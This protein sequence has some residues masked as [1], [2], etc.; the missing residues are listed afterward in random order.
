MGCARGGL[1]CFNL[2]GPAEWR[3]RVSGRPSRAC[4]RIVSLLSDCAHRETARPVCRWLTVSEAEIHERISSRGASGEIWTARRAWDAE[5][6][7]D[8]SGRALSRPTLGVGV[9]SKLGGPMRATPS[10]RRS[11]GPPVVYGSDRPR[12]IASSTSPRIQADR[13]GKE[14]GGR[15]RRRRPTV[16][17]QTHPTTWAKLRSEGTSPQTP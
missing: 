16:G 10:A 1:P 12:P 13:S 11:L 5:V 9:R 14:R 2:G 6:S 3:G 15:G 7:G 8:E 17:L 4:S